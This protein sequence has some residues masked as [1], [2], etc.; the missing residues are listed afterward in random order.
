M[1]NSKILV[2][3]AFFSIYVIWGSTYLW[4]K[5]AVAEIAPLF[6]ASQRFI[7]AGL[8]IMLIAKVMGFSLKITKRQLLNS[9]IAGFLFLVYG[10]GVFVWALKYVDSGFAALLA[11]TQ[12]LFV[13]F[14]LRLIDGKK[15]QRKSIIG[16]C[17]GLFGMYLL[18]SQKGIT[19]SEG[20]VLG[21]FMILTCVLSWS[22]G[23]VFVSKADLPK[24]FF[25]TTGYQMLIAGGILAAS[26]LLFKE[27]WISPLDLSFKVQLSMI[28]LVFFGGIVAFTA[29]N[30]LLKV[31]SPEKV[32]TSAYVNPVV[33]LLLGWYVLDENLTIQ[34]IIASGILL[35]G[36][37]FITSRKRVNNTVARKN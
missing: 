22:Y 34:S 9:A 12:P 37:Y 19:T 33:A 17:L 20:S 23:S 16:V 21:I 3:L 27:S 11:S 24:N 30:Y 13:L 28:L 10:N 5:I 35:T 8:L 25:V 15:M 32:A 14:L 26:S 7:V 18:V 31:V 6:L 1:K 36:V 2:V 29:F 4:N